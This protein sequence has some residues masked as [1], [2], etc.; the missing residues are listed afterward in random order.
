MEV[1]EALLKEAG[2]TFGA[3]LV[4][5]QHFSRR[6]SKIETALFGEKNE[7]TLNQRLRNIEHHILAL[8]TMNRDSAIAGTAQVF[9]DT[10]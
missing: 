9:K 4:F 3:L 6:F 7:P 10:E 1:I 8:G 2:L 5:V